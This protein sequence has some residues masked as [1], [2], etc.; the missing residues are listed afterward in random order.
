MASTQQMLMQEMVRCYMIFYS[1]ALHFSPFSL[2][3]SFWSGFINVLR[4]IFISAYTPQNIAG[5]IPDSEVLLPELLSEVGYRNKIIG[6][7]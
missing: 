4:L 5:G 2:S 6:K 7:W 3:I 1:D